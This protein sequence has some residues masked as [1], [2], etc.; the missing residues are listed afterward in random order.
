MRRVQVRQL[1]G[2]SYRFLA[3][4]PVLL[5]NFLLLIRCLLSMGME[6]GLLETTVVSE[7]GTL[8]LKACLVSSASGLMASLVSKGL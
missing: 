8:G 3:K 7:M 1:A 6:M 4:Q 5:K 2:R